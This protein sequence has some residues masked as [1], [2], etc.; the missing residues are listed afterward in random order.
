M[1]YS[2]L[3]LS[4][5][6]GQTMIVTAAFPETHLAPLPL[7]ATCRWR[8]LTTLECPHWQQPW[9]HMLKP[10]T[11]RK[12]GKMLTPTCRCASSLIAM[13]FYPRPWLQVDRATEAPFPLNPLPDNGIPSSPSSHAVLQTYKTQPVDS[14]KNERDLFT[15]S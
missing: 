2:K 8:I 9:G 13:S 3:N 4:P 15:K 11:T 1:S 14:E 7:Q 5:C 6:L 10:S 12:R